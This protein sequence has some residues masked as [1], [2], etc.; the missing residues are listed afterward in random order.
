MY[1]GLAKVTSETLGDSA[2]I[3]AIINDNNLLKL[4][5][6][7]LG[8][9]MKYD[10]ENRWFKHLSTTLLF[11]IYLGLLSYLAKYMM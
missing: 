1:R 2:Q 8:D 9:A 4:L 7:D 11:L 5:S 3:C 10:K 6:E